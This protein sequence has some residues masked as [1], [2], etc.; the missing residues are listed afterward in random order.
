MALLYR[1][2]KLISHL[3]IIKGG[4]IDTS[5]ATATQSDILSGKTAYVNGTKLTGT[6][7]GIT[8]T[9]S[10]EINSNGTYN[11]TNYASVNVNVPITEDSPIKIRVVT[12]L[13]TDNI[14]IN[15]LYVINQISYYDAFI[16]RNKEWLTVGKM[17]ELRI[18]DIE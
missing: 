10:V 14:D 3:D 17:T 12:T 13:P 7:E 6:Y 16:Y 8:P 11:V 5:D 2:N 18:R 9:G 1:G 4:G 15:S